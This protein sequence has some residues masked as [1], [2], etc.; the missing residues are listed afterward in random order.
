M[1]AINMA[2]AAA[3]FDIVAGVESLC[4]STSQPGEERTELIDCVDIHCLVA[5]FNLYPTT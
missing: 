5:Y 4:G 1:M 2:S 3:T